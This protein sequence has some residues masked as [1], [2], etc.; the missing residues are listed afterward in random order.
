MTDFRN[1]AAAKLSFKGDR[2]FFLGPNGQG[3]TN[4]LESIGLA[5]GLRSFRT[6]LKAP[7]VRTG[8]AQA[9]VRTLWRHEKRGEV[10]L[11]INLTP[12]H[13][14]VLLD[15][16]PLKSVEEI[17]GIFPVVTL[18]L[19]DRELI[20]GGPAIRRSE[21]DRLLC[22][23]HPPYYQV[24]KNYTAALKSRNLLLQEAHDNKAQRQAFEAQMA[25]HGAMMIRYRARMCQRLEA[26]MKKTFSFFCPIDEAPSLSYTPNTEPEELMQAWGKNLSA[27]RARG[28]TLYGPHRDAIDL[29]FNSQPAEE[30]ASEGQKFS[31]VLALKLAGVQLLEEKL[32]IAPVLI[33]DDLLLEL[34][35]QR[36]EKFWQVVGPWQVFASGTR[37][38]DTDQAPWQVWNVKNG[39]FSLA[40][41]TSK[42]QAM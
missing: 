8:A 25:E 26:Q 14:K 20:Y 24:I 3:K 9:T 6:H 42:L 29:L 35:G 28:A 31:L 27:E 34:D 7:M 11:G 33:A 5:Q 40:N 23:M 1:I 39:A 21:I 16:N 13:R 2:N 36:Q 15:E 38:P 37:L 17:L 22:Q 30:F 19:A 12:T 4:I 10:T 18:T 41:I 32:N